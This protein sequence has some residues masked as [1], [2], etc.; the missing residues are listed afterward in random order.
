MPEIPRSSPKPTNPPSNLTATPKSPRSI[1]LYWEGDSSGEGEFQLERCQ[2]NECTNFVVVA[3]TA[4]AL[5]NTFL[6]DGLLSNTTYCYRV[7]AYKGNRRLS[8]YSNIASAT[9]PTPM[10]T[11]TQPKP[12]SAKSGMQALEDEVHRASKVMGEAAELLNRRPSKSLSDKPSTD[13]KSARIQLI[14]GLCIGLIPWGLSLIGVTINIW[15]GCFI[16]AAT[17]IL[18]AHAFWIWERARRWPM[19]LRLITIAFAFI[20][21]AGF[22]GKQVITE[23]RQEHSE[24]AVVP[25]R[26]PVSSSPFMPQPAPTPTVLVTP[27]VQKERVNAAPTTIRGSDKTGATPTKTIE[28]RPTVAHLRFFVKNLTPTSPETPYVIQVTIQTDLA[29]EPTILFIHCDAVFESGSVQGGPSIKMNYRE[30]YTDGKT[31]YVVG[32]S[33]PPF[34]PESPLVITVTSRSPIRVKGVERKYSY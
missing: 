10:P 6:D 9:T 8:A 16:L 1:S 28:P 5:T 3:R 13:D 2:G 27:P 24:P 34:E 7:A 18:I 17:F 19:P 31:T 33:S 32:F 20:G 26:P 14:L 25:T 23:Y 22:V 15:L 12:S 4:V 29:F 11:P 30:G 21:S